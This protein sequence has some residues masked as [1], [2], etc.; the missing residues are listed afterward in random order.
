MKINQHNYVYHWQEWFSANTKPPKVDV[1]EQ[2][3]PTVIVH[4]ITK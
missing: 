1:S 3:L 4:N 2:L